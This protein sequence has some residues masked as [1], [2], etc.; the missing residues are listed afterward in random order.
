[1]RT[2]HHQLKRRGTPRNEL[3]RAQPPSVILLIQATCLLHSASV[4]IA[5]WLRSFF[6]NERT[7]H[8]FIHSRLGRPQTSNSC[9]GIHVPQRCSPRSTDVRGRRSSDDCTLDT[10]FSYASLVCKTIQSDGH[11][12]PS[13]RRL[14]AS[15]ERR[16]PFV[17]PALHLTLKSILRTDFDSGAC[18]ER[19]PHETWRREINVHSRWWR[20]GIWQEAPPASRSTTLRPHPLRV[21]PPVPK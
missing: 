12:P 8:T 9:S 10:C 11:R 4:R 21:S 13:I 16:C 6:P 1:M 19:T 7:S 17:S 2:T 14:T 18:C 3:G 5:Q 15:H 20:N